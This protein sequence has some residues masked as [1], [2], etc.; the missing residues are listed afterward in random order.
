MT[1]DWALYTAIGCLTI[2]LLV[3]IFLL[4][5]PQ[6]NNK[7]GQLALDVLQQQYRRELNEIDRKHEERVNRLQEQ[8]NSLEF[9]SRKRADLLDDD[10]RRNKREIDDL[11]QRMK[12]RKQ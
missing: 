9:V 12:P 1:R 6:H 7:A 2:A 3:C 8:I 4:A 5:A 11:R 10:V